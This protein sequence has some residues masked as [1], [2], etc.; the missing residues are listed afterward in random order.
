MDRRT[1]TVRPRGAV[2]GWPVPQQSRAGQ[3]RELRLVA[4]PSSAHDVPPPTGS[5]VTFE[6]PSEVQQ[7]DCNRRSICKAM[8]LCVCYAA[9]IGGTATLTGTGPNVVLL[10]QM[11]E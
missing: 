6:G 8:T 9:S 11:H 7:A 5:Q 4:R 10:G 3:G 2:V 1:G